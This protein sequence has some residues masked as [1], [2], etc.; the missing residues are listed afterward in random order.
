MQEMTHQDKKYIYGVTN[1]TEIDKE[2]CNLITAVKS[3]KTYLEYAKWRDILKQDDE[4][5][6]R[7]DEYRRELF[8]LQHESGD[9]SI[10]YRIEEFADRYAEFLENR[11]VSSFLDAE[12]NLCYMMQELTDKVVSSLDFE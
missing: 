1:M 4:L 10:K 7:V 9:P 2:V 6:A 8:A 3:S 11:V 12:N 5:R